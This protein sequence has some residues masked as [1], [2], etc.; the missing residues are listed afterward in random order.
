MSFTQ[1]FQQLMNGFSLGSL[2]ALLAIGYTLVYGILSLINFAHS[3]VFM[4]GAYFAFYMIAIFMIPWWLS[5]IIS[6]V[7][8][9]IVGMTI[10]R[11]AYRPLRS[12]PRIS[13]LITA[14]GVSYFLENL[15]L[16]VLGARPKGFPRPDLMKMSMLLPVQKFKG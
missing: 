1:F 3:D 8:C 10:E 13:A 5:V 7:L 16:V 14:V 11:V 6:V 9:A 12:A 4:L 15:G 2:Y